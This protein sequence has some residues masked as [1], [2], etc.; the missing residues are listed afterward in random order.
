MYE[1]PVPA[2]QRYLNE[3]AE[4]RAPYFAN[5]F[6]HPWLVKDPEVSKWIPFQ[7]LSLI[8]GGAMFFDPFS[9]ERLPGFPASGKWDSAI[10]VSLPVGGDAGPVL[11]RV[12][13]EHVRPG[14]RV[15]HREVS[16]VTSCSPFDTDDVGALRRVFQATNPGV[17]F[18]PIVNAFAETT[19]AEFRARGIPAYGFIPFQIDPIDSARRHGADERIFL[20][21]FTRGMTVM[22]ESLFELAGIRREQ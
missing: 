9:A 3:V 22:R 12:V 7:N 16:P 5:A 15:I 8:V 13:A 11:D 2:V 6:R 14:V 1:T 19:S 18:I 21:F 20:P 17:P 4:F 10:M